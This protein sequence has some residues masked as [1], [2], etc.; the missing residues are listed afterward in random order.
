MPMDVNNKLVKF[1][2][3]EMTI[4]P[5]ERSENGVVAA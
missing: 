1:K 3:L 4:Y 2:G 5:R